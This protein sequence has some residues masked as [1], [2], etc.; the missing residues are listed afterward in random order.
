MRSIQLLIPAILVLI[1]WSANSLDAQL[2][3]INPNGFGG[4]NIRAP[5]V[6]VITSPYGSHVRAP[7]VSVNSPPPA[8]YPQPR[9]YQG[10]YG[11]PIQPTYGTPYHSQPMPAQQGMI[12]PQPVQQGAFQQQPVQR[13]GVTQPQ[14]VQPQGV[15]QRQGMMQR[16]H[17]VQ[18]PPAT[19]PNRQPHQTR[20]GTI[21]SMPVQL[22]T[23]QPTPVPALNSVLD[24][25]VKPG[26]IEELPQPITEKDGRRK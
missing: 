26:S 9:Y 19:A 18:R 3:Q 6:R 25:P 14:P 5:F 15:I 10:Y 16:Q 2:I 22:G 11:Q 12:Q 4:V 7:F 23:G 20:G 8:Y 13:Q 1:C 24:R 21:K 17:V